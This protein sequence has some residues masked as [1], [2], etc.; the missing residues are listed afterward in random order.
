MR[1]LKARGNTLRRA[2]Y[3]LEEELLIVSCGDGSSSSSSISSSSSSNFSRLR[4]F[5]CTDVTSFALKTCDKPGIHSFHER[6]LLYDKELT[7]T[8]SSADTTCEELGGKMAHIQIASDQNKIV[9]LMNAHQETTAYFG[10]RYK[11]DGVYQYKDGT[12]PVYEQWRP[13]EPNMASAEPCVAVDT[14]YGEEGGWVDVGC[15]Y[16]S[17][18][19]WFSSIGH[20]CEFQQLQIGTDET[21]V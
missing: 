4:Q 8:Y 2:P 18:K 1:G 10:L 11:S 17:Y 16:D 14:K 19:P 5:R 13:G 12:S 21:G 15:T 20:V 6:L 7:T 3:L 9:W